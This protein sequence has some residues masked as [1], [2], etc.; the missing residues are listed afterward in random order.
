M[1]HNNLQKNGRKIREGSYPFQKKNCEEFSKTL[2]D[3]SRTPVFT[4]NSYFQ[5]F[6]INSPYGLLIFLIT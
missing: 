1:M 6:T 2:I 4:L 5:D 3:F